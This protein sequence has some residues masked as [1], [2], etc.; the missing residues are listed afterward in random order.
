MPSR[1]KAQGQARKAKRAAET[2]SNPTSAAAAC[3]HLGLPI[4]NWSQDD[5]D[6]VLNLVG[7]YEAK[8]KNAFSLFKCTNILQNAP[9]TPGIFEMANVTYDKYHQFNDARKELFRRTMLGG[10]TDVCMRDA[11]ETDF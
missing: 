11:N 3:Y 5:R 7:E 6:V 4:T 9:C 8:I 10:G 1:K 2:Q